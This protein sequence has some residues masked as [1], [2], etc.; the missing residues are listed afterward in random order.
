MKQELGIIR[1]FN[2]NSYL[3]NSTLNRCPYIQESI[4]Q[5]LLPRRSIAI[6]LLLQ[7][8]E[9]PELPTQPRLAS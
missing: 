9:D 2:A 5:I 8:A 4:S 7:L 6:L 1:L 3:H